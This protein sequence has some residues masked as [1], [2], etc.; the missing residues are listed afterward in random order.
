[1]PVLRAG[2]CLAIAASLCAAAFA[3]T[4]MAQGRSHRSV[5]L[6]QGKV[7]PYR[8][9]VGVSRS[10]GKNG[11]RRPCVAVQSEDTTATGEHDFGSS[12]SR[13][14][15]SLSLAG[16]SIDRSYLDEGGKDAA[17]VYALVFVPRVRTLQAVFENGGERRIPLR[18]L[19]ETQRR[20]AGV[21]PLRF[22]A[23]ALK[24]SVCMQRLI[25]YD[26]AGKVV[27]VDDEGDCEG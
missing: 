11:W 22:A 18:S 26:A 13:I 12:E 9:A 15:G 8:W 17:T 16:P 10:G 19:N 6:D 2:L 7:G 21:R 1:M 14:C 5:L 3:E 4:A 27:Y 24:G 23:F 25:G 20:N